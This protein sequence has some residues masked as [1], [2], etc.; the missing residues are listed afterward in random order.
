[1]RLKFVATNRALRRFFAVEP[2]SRLIDRMPDHRHPH[3]SS[4]RRKTW[5]AVASLAALL[6]V[7]LVSGASA[8]LDA[9]GE[10]GVDTRYTPTAKETTAWV[11]VA[12]APYGVAA[13]PEDSATPVE[14]DLYTVAFESDLHGFAGG[15]KCRDA[16]PDGLT[17]DG[18]TDYLLAC[19]RVPVIYEFTEDEVE[20][21]WREIYRGDE[22]GYVGGIAFMRDGTALA[23]GGNGK[24]PRREPQLSSPETDIAGEGRAWI[25]DK[26]L[27][28]KLDPSKMQPGMRGM[29]AVGMSERAGDCEDR[30][31][32]G[33]AGAYRQLWQWRDTKFVRGYFPDPSEVP[34]GADAG[35]IALPADFRFRVRAIR[36]TPANEDHVVKAVA[37]TSGCCAASPV[38]NT[39]RALLMAEGETGEMT[40]YTRAWPFDASANARAERRDLPESLYALGFYRDGTA[41]L[42]SAVAAAAAPAGSSPTDG[43]GAPVEPPADVPESPLGEVASRVLGG[44]TLA[45]TASPGM[46]GIE[47]TPFLAPDLSNARLVAGD[48]NKFNKGLGLRQHYLDWAVGSWLE[49]RDGDDQALAFFTWPRQRSFATAPIPTPQVLECPGGGYP[50]AGSGDDSSAGADAN[51]YPSSEP[52]P[53]T[54]CQPYTSQEDF[55]AQL[56]SKHLF[57]LPTYA[58]NSFT[59]S[60]P[61]TESVG[62]GVGDRGAIVR[63]GGVGTT[64]G[65]DS[66][67]P[68][69]KLGGASPARFAGSEVYDAFRPMPVDAD[70]PSVPS[71]ASGETERVDRPRFV[72]GGAPHPA[73]PVSEPPEDVSSIVMSRD[74]GEGW[75]VGS[76]ELT[77]GMLP[78]GRPAP[79]T[80]HFDG[81]R[82]SRCDMRGVLDLLP[83][84]PACSALAPLWTG[85]QNGAP[86]ALTHATRVP[87]ENDDD[88]SNDNEFELAAV[89]AIYDLPGDTAPVTALVRYRE[90]RWFID[91]EGTRQFATSPDPQS[92]HSIAFTAPDDGW[93]TYGRVQDGPT[94][95]HWD[96]ESWW[97]CNQTPQIAREHCDDPGDRL[98]LINAERETARVTVAGKRI[99]MI[100]NR[101]A[102]DSQ[103][104]LATSSVTYPMI[105]YRDPGGEWTAENGGYDPGCESQQPQTNPAQR[106][107][108]VPGDSGQ[109]EITSLGVARGSGGYVGWAIGRFGSDDVQEIVD[110]A[111]EDRVEESVADDRALLRLDGGSWVSWEED[112]ASA[113]YLVA[114]N[115]GFRPVV[116][117]PESGSAVIYRQ[118]N[119]PR[120][121]PLIFDPARGALG[122]WRILPLPYSSRAFGSQTRNAFLRGIEPDGQGGAWVAARTRFSASGGP[123]ARPRESVHFWHYTTDIPKPVFEEAPHPIR[124]PITAGVAGADGSLWVTTNSSF[125]YRYDR[126]TGWDKLRIPG[127]DPGRVV[128]RASE[129]NAVAV[130]PDGEGLVVGKNGRMADLSPLGVQ[131]N[132]AAGKHCGDPPCSSGHDLRAVAIAP[133]G[134]AL[135]GGDAGTLLHRPAANAAFERVPLPGTSASIAVTDISM[136][137]SDQAWVTTDAGQVFGGTRPAGGDWSF[138]VEN[139][140]G[141]TLLS[142]DR[143]NKPLALAAIDVDKE[144]EGYAVGE[145]GLILERRGAD[146]WQRIKTRFLDNFRSIT[147]AP[148]GRD[149]GALLGGDMGLILTLDDGE[150]RVAR[151]A[152]LFDPLNFG[153]STTQAASIRGVALVPG[154]KAG[155][156]EAWAVQQAGSG[157]RSGPGAVFHYANDRNDPLLRPFGRVEPLPDTPAPIDGEISFAAFGRSD[158][159][160][161]GDACPEAQGE[162]LFHEVVSRRVADEVVARSKEDGGPSFAVFTGDVGRAAGREDEGGNPLHRSRVHRRW[163][164]LVADRLED[165]DVPLFGAIGLNDLDRTRQCAIPSACADAK[166]SSRGAGLS[167]GWRDAMAGMRDPWGAAKPEE[168]EADAHGLEYVAVSQSGTTAPVGGEARTHY[169]VDV[170]RGESAIARL[171]FI[172]NSLRTL[173]ASDPNQNPLEPQRKWL[174]DVLATVPSGAQPVVVM[175]TP[176]YSYTVGDPT[177]WHQDAAALETMLMQNN[178][179]AV[180]SGRLGWNG[181]YWTTAPGV[182][183][184][185]PGCGYIHDDNAPEPNEPPQC[186][187]EAVTDGVAE[188]QRELAEAMDTLGAPAPPGDGLVTPPP[189]GLQGLLPFVVASSA[190]GTFGPTGTGGGNASDGWWHGYTVVR[191]HPDGDPRKT[192]VEQRP[193]FDWLSITAATHV[194]KPRQRMKLRGEGREPV[195]ID[196]PARYDAID[197]PAI[198]HR[199]D[200]VM[201]DEKNPSIPRKDEKGG[202]VFV[203]STV[204]TVDD[205][206]TVRAGAG[207]QER[208]YAIAILSV[209]SKAASWPLVFE[210]AKSFEPRP[211]A[212]VSQSVIRTPPQPIQ[213]RPTPPPPVVLNSPPSPTPPPPPPANIPQVTLPTLKLPTPPGFPAIPPTPAGTPTP[214][215]PPPAAPPAPPGSAGALPLTLEAPITPISIVPTVIPPAPPPVNP[216]PPSGGAARKEARQRQAATAKS[217]EGG[218][219]K[220]AGETQSSGEGG[221]SSEMTRRDRARPAPSYD[222]YSRDDTRYSFT[223]VSHGEQASAWSQGALYGGMT[224][225]TALVLALGWGLARP[226][227]KRRHPPRPAPET[228]RE[229]PRQ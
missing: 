119:L 185:G 199:Y 78:S 96:G 48:G 76:A 99:Y 23:V 58:L 145:A 124:E 101:F 83:A 111:V 4:P 35:P 183:H 137:T 43:L 127:W 133:D 45:N 228:V 52:L 223:A 41:L 32:C 227:P 198:T 151:E 104:S 189:T 84:D 54:R 94:V 217:E 15:A 150:F 136:P 135:A 112:D 220:G 110:G 163:V 157:G 202:Y 65:A 92:I 85:G 26:V 190:G 226:T 108:C 159:H 162:R 160:L 177:H 7:S 77:S 57:Q 10:T 178:V 187:T 201:A 97:V 39:A 146:G 102:T 3:T 61:E 114:G 105:I 33:L 47:S 195:G 46:F 36:F 116:L 176:T 69:P 208:T 25:W 191:L 126:L 209:G 63:L 168:E 117:D 93:I 8:Q 5:P 206:G 91:E 113:D 169:A 27:W 180:V 175:N 131:L 62:W 216:A 16:P 89:G 19:E 50:W 173:E 122:R 121:A 219:D 222:S 73:P 142:R 203:P 147:L 88:P 204:G 193:I 49:G 229:R 148:R 74:G 132:P 194:L 86:V 68:E 138:T 211:P 106:A 70:V 9:A 80:Y 95:R 24:Y 197:S 87:L 118:E 143:Q 44:V 165:G 210:P 196:V 51:L 174:Q 55:E 72:A 181:R 115:V 130:G 79:V 81:T 212:T 125:V 75:A 224:L 14:V 120:N 40:A 128:T 13:A 184:P 179:K 182:H 207:R 82:W 141:N 205:T 164:E 215:P 2:D 31:Q 53:D 90:G 34:D 109:G 71:L 186:G 66:E 153:D 166:T 30:E 98:P 12:G 22:T 140:K 6:A 20:A 59:F 152:D 29:T 170:K 17:G 161:V 155:Q 158:C 103:A 221:S 129:A 213:P 21:R 38:D 18:L 139:R 134:S 167:W 149:G 172:D 60:D 107:E 156:V 188:A 42:I 123:G 64:A 11:R 67:P 144:G 171:I 225:A 28:S 218:G 37:V 1:M 214:A 200:L 56:A 100:G 192:I 154:V